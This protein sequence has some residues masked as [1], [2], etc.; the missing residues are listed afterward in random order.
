MFQ[1]MAF[2]AG[3]EVA[4]NVVGGM[5]GR[6]NTQQAAPV[7]DQSIQKTSTGPCQRFNDS[8]VD[9]LKFNNQNI[10]GCQNQLDSLTHLPLPCQFFKLML[11]KS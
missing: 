7:Q 3:S 1:G 5:M 11:P 8:F 6:G 2:G 9:C 10:G 4:H